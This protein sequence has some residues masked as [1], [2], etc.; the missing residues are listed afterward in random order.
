MRA[1]H[2]FKLS[3]LAIIIF[4]LSFLYTIYWVANTLSASKKTLNNYQQLKF[5]IAI[6][7]NRTISQYLEHGNATLLTK[8]NKQLEDISV[9]ITQV[10]QQHLQEQLQKSVKNLKELLTTTFRSS[11]KLSGNLDALLRNSESS[12]VSLN[13]QLAV[14]AVNSEGITTEE[15]IRYLIAT[16]QLASALNYLMMSREKSLQQS[17]SNNVNDNDNNLITLPLNEVITASATFSELPS[18]HIYDSV[19]EDELGID[20]DEEPSELSSEAIAELQSI[21]KRYKTELINTLALYQQQKTSLS[22]LKNKISTFENIIV[23]GEKSI[24]TKQDKTTKHVT[25]ITVGLLS[26]LVLFLI[27]NHLLQ[28][29]IIL[30]PLRLLRNSFVQLIENGQV[31][32]I[33]SISNKTELGEIAESFNQMIH[34][35][36][37]D[38]EQKSQQLTLVSGVLNNMKNQAA[39]IQVTSE[40]TTEQVEV[41]HEI[42]NEL[43][44][45]TDKVNE[46]SQEA[47]TNAKL[48]QDAMLASKAEVAHALS[49]SES[50]NNAALSGKIAIDKLEGSVNSV[51]SIIEVISAIADQTNLLA[52]NAAI[53]AAR[54]GE[55]G[56]GFSVVATEVRQLAG[57]TQDSLQQINDKLKQLQLDTGSIDETMKSIE[58]ASTKQQEVALALQENALQV[59]EQAQVSAR[60]AQETLGHITTQKSHFESFESAMF[61]VNKEV[62]QSKDLAKE[63][64]EQVNSQVQDISHTLRAA[65]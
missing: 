28:H 65:S 61:N 58:L 49:T 5:S 48:T 23:D 50:T 13:H 31:N 9:K 26:F 20:E 34:R 21:A 43:S 59:S 44:I 63:I 60:V 24:N 8:A 36:A 45:A 6:D 4:T 32:A 57:R 40:N 38:T 52:L 11:G 39:N 22:L 10:E 3:S 33:K 1:S 12:L 18:L 35:L 56:R 29:K 15:R 14:Y 7:F 64:T 46:L 54:A 42:M 19:D 17:N 27:I 51:G 16:E 55:H 53:E 25:I 41:V 2:F 37:Q 62:A 30:Q 47:A